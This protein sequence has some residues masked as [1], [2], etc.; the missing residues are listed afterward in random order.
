MMKKVGFVLA[1]AALGLAASSASASVFFN[2]GFNYADGDLTITDGT[3]DDVSGGLWVPHSGSTFGD[4]IQVLSGHAE[5][6]ASGS[7]DAHRDAGAT[8]AAG[9]KWYAAF[10]FKVR[11]DRADPNTESLNNDYFAHFYA[12]SSTFRG[13]VYMDD[14]NVAS[15]TKFTLGLSATSGGQTQKWATD[16]S[17][18]TYYIAVV[19]YDFD[20]GASSMWIDPVTEGST[21]VTESTTVGATTAINAFAFRQDF[22]GGTPNNAVLINQLV[23]GSTFDEVLAGVPEPA[24]LALLGLGGLT[25]LRRRR[26]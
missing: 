14:P 26:A 15:P 5:V 1:V 23:L 19:S 10:Q 17:F 4:N 13:R 9:E 11:D 25:L 16:L 8:M 20:T 2:E 18:D 6:R 3:G 24:S 7:E 22:V 12:N 21:S